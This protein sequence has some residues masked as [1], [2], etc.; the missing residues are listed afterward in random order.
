M[1]VEGRCDV[2]RLNTRHTEVKRL[3]NGGRGSQLGVLGLL[4]SKG[5]TSEG[6]RSKV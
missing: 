2:V 3:L 1:W 6:I 5:E 4:Y